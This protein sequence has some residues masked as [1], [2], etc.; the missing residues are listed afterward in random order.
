LDIAAALEIKPD[1]D[2][3]LLAMASIDKG[4]RDTAR[5]VLPKLRAVNA[6]FAD[7]VEKRL[8]PR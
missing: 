8:A 1:F 7:Q 5:A 2:R 3:A 6:T 4:D